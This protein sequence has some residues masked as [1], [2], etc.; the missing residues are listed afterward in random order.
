MLFSDL[1]TP[2]SFY[3]IETTYCQSTFV[4]LYSSYTIL[5]FEVIHRN[6][7]FCQ[8]KGIFLIKGSRLLGHNT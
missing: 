3:Q 5:L 7:Y 1:V 8:P 4:Q 2:C 6:S